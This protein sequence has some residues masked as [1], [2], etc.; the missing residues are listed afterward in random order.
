M[1][2]IATDEDETKVLLPFLQEQMDEIFPTIQCDVN[3]KSTDAL[4]CVGAEDMKECQF[5]RNGFRE[6]KTPVCGVEGPSFVSAAQYYCKTHRR[7][8]D[9]A[10]REA[11]EYCLEND[12]AL[13]N[14]FTKVGDRRFT[15]GALIKIQLLTM[16]FNYAKQIRRDFSITWCTRAL[17]KVKK[18]LDQHIITSRRGCKATTFLIDRLAAFIPGPHLFVE[19]QLLIFNYIVKPNI[20]NYDIALAV[21]DGQIIRFDVTWGAAKFVYASD[22]NKSSR[23]LQSKSLIIIPS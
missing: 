4:R 2:L 6:F 5:K 9:T 12:I 21:F 13:I 3:M 1:T 19:V 11:R 18:L 14:D 16:D 20:T 15:D 8:F 22:G 10:S 7:Q 23:K 17:E